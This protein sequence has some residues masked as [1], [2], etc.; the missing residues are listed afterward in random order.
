MVWY[1]KIE[2]ALPIDTYREAWTPDPSIVF[3]IHFIL[4]QDRPLLDC[5]A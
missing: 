4:P 1:G 5:Y 3:F 2:R